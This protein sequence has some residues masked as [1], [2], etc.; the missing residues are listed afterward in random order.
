[1]D[2]YGCHS[3]AQNMTDA[4]ITLLCL[5]TLHSFDLCKGTVMVHWRV[6]EVK[7]ER[8]R[9]ERNEQVSEYITCIFVVSWHL[10]ELVCG[11]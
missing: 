8:V 7:S 10:N 5:K 1:M 2:G 3:S 11:S 4:R 9:V 6:R